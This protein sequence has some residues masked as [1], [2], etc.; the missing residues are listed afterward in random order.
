MGMGIRKITSAKQKVKKKGS[1]GGID[2]PK[3]GHF[4]VYVGEMHKRYVIP[5]S[6]LD[7]PLFRDLLRWAEEEF[8]FDNSEV[9]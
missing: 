1:S 4:A 8:G 9:D 5:L 3:K 7:H 2:P 6:T